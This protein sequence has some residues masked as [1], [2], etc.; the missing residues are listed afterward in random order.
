[1]YPKHGSKFMLNTE[2]NKLKSSLLKQRQLCSNA[3]V[4]K[5]VEYVYFIEEAPV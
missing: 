3:T 1:M 5:E 2:I 4:K